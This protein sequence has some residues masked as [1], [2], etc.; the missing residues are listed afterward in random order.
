[1][2]SAV[3]TGNLH[4]YETLYGYRLIDNPDESC[5]ESKELKKEGIGRIEL[6]ID[7]R[8][9]IGILGK[10][11]KITIEEVSWKLDVL[12]PYDKPIVRSWR[13]GPTDKKYTQIHTISGEYHTVL[14]KAEFKGNSLSLLEVIDYSE[15]DF[16]IENVYD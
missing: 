6:G 15:A 9:L 2:N 13:A 14:I 8:T 7:S 11:D 5:L 10:P 3:I 12:I 4:D 1:M 16:N